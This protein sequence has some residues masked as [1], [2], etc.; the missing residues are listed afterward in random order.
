MPRVLPFN[1]GSGRHVAMRLM[2][3]RQSRA[4]SAPGDEDEREQEAFQAFRGYSRAGL[5]F[6]RHPFPIGWL[7]ASRAVG[8]DP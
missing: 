7:L 8:L 3:A 2:Q 5:I 4:P 1:R 6:A